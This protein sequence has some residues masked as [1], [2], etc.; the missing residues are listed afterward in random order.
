M[1]SRQK[2]VLF[3]IDGTLL[4]APRL[5]RDALAKAAAEVF[6]Q[7]LGRTTEAINAIDF[8]GATDGRIFSDFGEALIGEAIPV[9][10][11][12]A[13]RYLQVLAQDTNQIEVSVLPGVQQLLTLLHRQSS[14]CVGLLTGNIRAAAAI[15]LKRVGLDTLLDGP[16][17]FA[18][19]GI[20][21]T[22]VAQRAFERAASLGARPE[23]TLVIGDTQHDVIAAH[24]AGGT[25]IAVGSGWT[26]MAE[27]HNCG[28]QLVLEDL[29]NPHVVIDFLARL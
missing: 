17:G 14:T 29:S 4:K 10:G 6:Q 24:H 1:T 22:Q 26:D 25:A 21:R 3:D 12:F 23:Q 18:E 5:G 11:A 16:G 13:E 15:K 19:D 7:P 2:A 20:E 9:S 27:L 8:R 28:A